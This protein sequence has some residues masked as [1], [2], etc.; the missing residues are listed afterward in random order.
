MK[1]FCF[2]V[3][4]ILFQAGLVVS[5]QE[6]G[7][8]LAEGDRFSFEFP[9][10][11]FDRAA[12]PGSGDQASFR[13]NF[14]MVDKF[15]RGE[16]INFRLFEDS[17]FKSPFFE[18]SYALG[19]AERLNQ[20]DS[21][22][23]GPAERRWSDLQGTIQIEMIS[24]SVVVDSLSFSVIRGGERFTGVFA[25]PEPSPIAIGAVAVSIFWLGRRVLA[26]RKLRR[27]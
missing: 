19:P 7:R 8:R 24:G 26:A 13:V 27:F 21:L 20:A 23:F 11:T 4:C 16:V 22:E 2:S 15:D 3:L 18:L 14:G 9:G 10:L 6:T 1:R 5:A 25:V 12:L 17:S